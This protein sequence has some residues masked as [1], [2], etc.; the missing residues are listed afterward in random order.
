[1]ATVQECDDAFRYLAGLLDKVPPD[2]RS[3]YLLTRSVSCRVTDLGVTWSA[4]LS[5]D[6]LHGITTEQDSKAQ[7]R[8]IV[9]SDDLLAMIE[10]RQPIPSAWATGRLRVQAG[11]RDMLR[12]TSMLSL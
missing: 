9:T 12:L 10:G 1:V 2:L 8:V 11:P 4:Q 3:K 5:D 7:I 6:G